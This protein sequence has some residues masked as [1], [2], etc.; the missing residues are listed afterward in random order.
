MNHFKKHKKA[1]SNITLAAYTDLWT[2]ILLILLVNFDTQ[3]ILKLKTM[4]CLDNYKQ[5]VVN[6]IMAA[7][8]I[9]INGFN[10]KICIFDFTDLWTAVSL[11]PLIDFDIQ[12][13]HSQSW[14]FYLY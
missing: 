6:F 12:A 7:T 4:N 10:F 3:A 9:L 11:I 5:A 14:L 1:I 8:K 13:Y 2:S